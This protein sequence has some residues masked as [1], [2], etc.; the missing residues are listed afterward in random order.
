[1]GGNGHGKL[2]PLP[3]PLPARRF[4]LIIFI[5][6]SKRVIHFWPRVDQRNSM[7]SVWRKDSTFVELLYHVRFPGNESRNEICLL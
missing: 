7:A 6:D 2:S 4:H 3:P 5:P 1:M